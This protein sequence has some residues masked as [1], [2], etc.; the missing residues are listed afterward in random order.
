[1]QYKRLTQQDVD[2]IREQR[3]AAHARVWDID[4]QVATL[5]AERR[6]V[7]RLVSGENLCDVYGVSPSTLSRCL[8]GGTTWIE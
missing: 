6:Q 5:K 2:T 8:R 1:M 7:Q 3:K 4:E